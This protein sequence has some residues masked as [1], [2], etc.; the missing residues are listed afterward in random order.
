MARRYVHHSDDFKRQAVERMKAC[1]SVR[2]LSKELNVQR[3]LLY[4]WKE[5]LE[6]TP[7]APVRREGAAEPNAAAQIGQLK[8]QVARLETAL[9]RKVLEVDFFKAALQKVEARRQSSNM[10][11]SAGSTTRSGK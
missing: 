4:R 9:G 1:A 5:E 2:D 3:R 11:G 7:E 10:S 6:P 8:Q